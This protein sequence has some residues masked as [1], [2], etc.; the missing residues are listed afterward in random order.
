MS[1]LIQDFEV[2]Q[3]IK[4]NSENFIL[5]ITPPHPLPEIKPGQFVE[6]RV[7]FAPDT[8][9]RRPISVFDISY[10]KNT[11]S[12]LIKLVGE[13]TK[14]L[15][16]LERGDVIN[17]I[18]PLGNSFS[19]PS[20][21][22]ALLI[23]GGIGVAPLLF[24]G[25]YLKNHRKRPTFLLGF[26]SADLVIDLTEFEKLGKVYI[27]TDDGTSGEEG[28]VTHHS[29]LKP[30]KPGFDI[31]Y[32]CGPEVMMKAVGEY[33]ENH[34]INC[35]VSLE[36]TMA[37]GFGVCLCCVR[38]TVFGNKMVCTDGPVFKTSEIIWQT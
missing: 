10:D 3:N 34:G 29:I 13:G 20:G 30:A 8:F 31:I 36:N 14:K 38:K 35:E 11:L 16:Q 21:K 15:S 18:Y 1:K 24:L 19:L 25:K 9:L 7:D 5:V 33:A 32:A 6:I 27:T 22:N 26:R 37:C 2:V 4:L 28:L 12:L 17:L 23:G